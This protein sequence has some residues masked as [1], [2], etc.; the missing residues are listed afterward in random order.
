V[1]GDDVILEH[2]VLS[3]ESRSGSTK[4]VLDSSL[5]SVHLTKSGFDFDE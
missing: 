1:R 5:S 4:G 3:R 2:V